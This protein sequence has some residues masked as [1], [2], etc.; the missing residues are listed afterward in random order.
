MS[1]ITVQAARLRGFCAV[2]LREGAGEGIL[3][4]LGAGLVGCGRVPVG[5]GGGVFEV[6]G[7]SVDLFRENPVV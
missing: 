4:R 7:R 6:L 2:P 1:E 3:E 5:Q